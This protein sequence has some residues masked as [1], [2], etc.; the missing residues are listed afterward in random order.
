MMNIGLKYICVLFSCTQRFYD[1][2]EKKDK[3]IISPI[4]EIKNIYILSIKL[5]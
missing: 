4:C 3:Y 5:H 2:Y 1:I